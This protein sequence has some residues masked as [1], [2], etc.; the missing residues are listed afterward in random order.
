VKLLKI[1]AAF[2]F[3]IVGSASTNA[4]QKADALL[5]AGVPEAFE[6]IVADVKIIARIRNNHEESDAAII[7]NRNYDGWFTRFRSK[8][9]SRSA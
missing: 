3:V 2:A 8:P 4:H 9:C 1:G 5:Y 7:D 6:N